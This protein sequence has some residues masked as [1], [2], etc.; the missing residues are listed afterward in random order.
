MLQMNRGNSSRN[1]AIRKQ[2]KEMV[3]AGFQMKLAISIV[4]ERFYLSA[5]T[6]RDIVYDKRRK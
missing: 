4:A 6:V 1:A 3:A 5:A 2:V